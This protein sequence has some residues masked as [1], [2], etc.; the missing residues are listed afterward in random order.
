MERIVLG[1]GKLYIDEFV[2]GATLPTDAVI[3]VETKLLGLI[4]GGAS[5]SYTPTF[6]THEDD[7]GLIKKTS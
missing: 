6:V 1:S 7:L 5:V 2:K 3:E 4:S